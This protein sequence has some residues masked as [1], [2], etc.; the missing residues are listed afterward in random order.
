MLVDAG[1]CAILDS[2]EAK[3]IWP[4]ENTCGLK[5]LVDID[6]NLLFHFPEQWSNDQIWYALGFANSVSRN[7]CDGKRRI[8][9][10]I[11][12]MNYVVQSPRLLRSV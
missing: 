7:L 2:D 9:T 10:E 3:R 5:Y 1:D 6:N 12:Q 4:H 11:S 8:Q